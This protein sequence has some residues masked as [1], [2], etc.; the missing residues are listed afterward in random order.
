MMVSIKFVI[1]WDFIILQG[2][3]F[4]AEIVDGEG[5]RRNYCP[6][7]HDKL[8]DKRFRCRLCGR[9][10][11]NRRTCPRS[12]SNEQKK[13]VPRNHNCKICGQ[14]GHNKR[15]CPQLLSQTDVE[16]NAVA[17]AASGAPIVSRKGTYT[18]HICHEKGH[19][20]RTCP[21]RKWQVGNV[22]AYLATVAFL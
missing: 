14:S 12:K 9:K 21:R 20:I 13:S 18:C 1:F 15:T 2:W 8:I 10:G 16:S 11:H 19:N 17:A 6:E 4:T 5:H 7:V 22:I 3:N